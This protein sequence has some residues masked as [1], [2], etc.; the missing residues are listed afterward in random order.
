MRS[1]IQHDGLQSVV[2]VEDGNL[3]TGTVQDCTPIL[4]RAQALHRE[5]Q[6]GSSEMKH[7]ASF[8]A[9]LV[10]KYCNDNGIT[11]HEFMNGKEHV[12]RMLND[13]SLSYFRIWA[14]KV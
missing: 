2:A 8:P 11:F 5:G 12:K 6:H 4:E 10:E 9:V 7:A 3:I 13:P 1:V 14:G